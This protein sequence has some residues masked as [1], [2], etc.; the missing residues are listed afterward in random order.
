MKTFRNRLVKISR[1][2][3]I[4]IILAIAPVIF[5]KDYDNSDNDNSDDYNAF[6]MDNHTNPDK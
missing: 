5:G 1:I 2:I 6:Y 3:L 4:S